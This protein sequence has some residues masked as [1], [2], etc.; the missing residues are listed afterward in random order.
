[1]VRCSIL[2]LSVSGLLLTGAGC[3]TVHNFADPAFD[4]TAQTEV[5]GGVTKA[6]LP[7]GDMS[8]PSGAKP[9]VV[10]LLFFAGYL[11]DPILSFVGDTVTL[12]I[13]IPMTVFRE[14]RE[15]KRHVEIVA[16]IRNSPP[17]VIHTTSEFPDA[18][19]VLPGLVNPESFRWSAT[20]GDPGRTPLNPADPYF[21]PSAPAGA[22]P[23]APPPRVIATTP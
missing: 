10:A 7:A 16:S 21:D 19:P 5:Y 12:P 11:A 22:S 20:G 23:P 2:M 4:P 17:P 6:A 13:T 8:P 9:P 18:S 14:D 15:A 3:G 1:M